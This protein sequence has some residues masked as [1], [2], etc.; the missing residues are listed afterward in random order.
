METQLLSL[1]PGIGDRVSAGMTAFRRIFIADPAQTACAAVFEEIRLTAMLRQDGEPAEGLFLKEPSG[2]GKSTVAKRYIAKVEALYGAVEGKGPA[3]LI[4]VSEE[5]TSPSFWSSVLE[6]LGDP[7]YATGSERTLKKRVKK[8]IRRE[9]IQLL[10]IDE[11]NHTVD[12]SHAKQIMNAIKN[13]ITEGLVSIVA[14]GSSEE[15]NTLVRNDAFEARMVDGPGLPRRT[16][17]HD[18]KE[19]IEF[20][21]ALDAKMVDEGILRSHSDLATEVRARAL[22]VICDGLIGRLKWVIGTALRN[23]LRRGD[24]CISLDDLISAGDALLLKYPRNGAV[25]PLASLR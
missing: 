17:Q 22:L 20:C 23:A 25:N 8:A 6:Y 9:G 7:Y 11:L 10:F 13:M 1:I 5:G 21:K 15:L 19:W 3:R 14:M 16:W 2:S 24:D 18:A 4:T 12:K